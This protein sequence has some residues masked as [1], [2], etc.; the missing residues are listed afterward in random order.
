MNRKAMGILHVYFEIILLGA[1]VG[2]ENWFLSRLKL[3]EKFNI[4][5]NHSNAN[6]TNHLNGIFKVLAKYMVWVFA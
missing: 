2:E 5:A 1:L 3:S 4:L 6:D